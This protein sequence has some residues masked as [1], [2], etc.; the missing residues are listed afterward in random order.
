MDRLAMEAANVGT[1]A[2]YVPSVLPSLTQYIAHFFSYRT[3]SSTVTQSSISKCGPD[4]WVDRYRPKKFT[5]LVGDERVNRE[6]M[7]WVKEWDHCV[8]GRSKRKRKRESEGRAGKTAESIREWTSEEDPWH[9]PREKVC[10]YVARLSP[11]PE[12]IVW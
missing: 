11:N 5:D 12:N 4:M 9:R 8:F 2:S 1:S 7:A 3:S 6:A 10:L